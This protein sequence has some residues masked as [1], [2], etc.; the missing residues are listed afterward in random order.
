MV[1]LRFFCVVSICLVMGNNAFAMMR[2]LQKASQNLLDA[3]TL[4]PLH[5]D[6]ESESDEDDATDDDT[7]DQDS[8]REDEDQDESDEDSRASTSASDKDEDDND[9]VD[10]D[11]N[12]EVEESE[13]DGAKL[14]QSPASAVR[15][16]PIEHSRQDTAA[17][18][19]ITNIIV[20]DTLLDEAKQLAPSTETAAPAPEMNTGRHDQEIVSY[21]QF[22]RDRCIEHVASAEI[23]GTPI[24]A[25]SVCLDPSYIE[26]SLSN[27]PK[28]PMVSPELSSPTNA[29]MSPAEVNELGEWHLVEY[30]GDDLL[31]QAK[32]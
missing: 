6:D 29:P 28:S 9:E 15:T 7:T 26:A 31:V 17:E 25:Q 22:L 3:I 18:P 14:A 11:D 19:I 24:S 20:S 13:A 12:D 23:L 27:D 4:M 16:D 21:E 32:K 5:Y 2:A 8:E 30:G 10:E 1:K